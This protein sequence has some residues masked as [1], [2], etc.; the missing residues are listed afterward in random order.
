M[1]NRMQKRITFSPTVNEARLEERLVLSSGTTA[2]VTPPPAPAPFFSRVPFDRGGHR[3]TVAELRHAY[4]Q[5]V[6]SETTALR[7]EMRA[8]VQQLRANGSTPTSQQLAD[9]DATM[10][11]AI[12]A[13]ALS[14][15]SQASLLPNSATRLVPAIQN[16]LLGSGPNSLVSRLNTVTQSSQDN[17]TLANLQSVLSRQ[18]NAASRQ[19]V[20]ELN[21]FFNTTSVSGLSVNS[22]GQH[23][24]LQQ[25]IGGQIASQLGNTLGTLA[26]SYSNVA[27]SALFPN[28]TTATP[29]QSAMSAF[30]S[31]TNSA[32]QTVAFALGNDLALFNGYPSVATQIAPMLFST[33]SSST[34]LASVLQNLPYGNTTFDTAVANA[35]NTGYQNLV[36]S[37]SPFFQMASQSNLSLPT[38][39]LTNLF[40][41]QFSG[42]SF[43]SG[44]N[45]GFATGTN[46]GFIGF[47]QAP[48]DFN[49]NFGTGFSNLVSTV[50]QNLDIS[51]PS[52]GTQTT[53]GGVPVQSR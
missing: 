22:S 5:Q 44:F 39:G 43:N 26:Q 49:T 40:G 14:L 48:A 4:D 42:S 21:N 12:N 50:D 6:R 9:F 32:L 17:G 16:A 10:A 28:G 35:F 38:S 3:L 41:S 24:P 36:S 51:T 37:L 7:R 33:G 23:I 46:T 45:N 30:S 25:Y 31:Q 2:V 19:N 53:E 34:S 47:G 27:N 20:A 29:T 52:L 11:G 1:N 15:S 18:I 13:T 8:E